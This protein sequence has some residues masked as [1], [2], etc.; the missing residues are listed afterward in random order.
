MTVVRT[1]ARRLGS[2]WLACAALA[3]LLSACSGGNKLPP[4]GTP[5]LTLSSTNTQF[6]SYVVTI[7]AIS[8]A[9]P[10]GVYASLLYQPLTFDL[11]RQTDITELVEAPAVPAD[12]YT[13]ATITIDYSAAVLTINENGTSHQ[14]SPVLLV[15]GQQVAS[16]SFVVTFD[17]NHPLVVTNQ[18]STRL[19]IKFDLDAMNTIDTASQQV[20]IEPF[21]V[22]NPASP[23]LDQTPMR[24]R[25]L[26]VY[27]GTNSFVMNIRPFYNLTAV[28]LGGITVTVDDQTYYNINGVT[29]QGA[30]GLAQL[31]SLPLNTTMAA[32]GVLSSLS[33]ITPTF[34]ATT[35]LMGTSLEDPLQDHLRGVV[36]KRTG[37]DLI[38]SGSQQLVAAAGNA[39]NFP[40]AVTYAPS[41]TVKLSSNTIVSKDGTLGTFGLNDI[42][43]GQQVDVGGTS[44]YDSSG[45]LTFDATSA[46]LRLLNSRAWGVLNSATPNSASL[47]LITFGLWPATAFNF[48][49]TAQ[50]G[51]AVDPAAYP[52][53]TG[54][55]DL[56]GTAAGTL[57]A[58]DGYVVPFGTAPP[59]FNAT[60]ITPG[61]STEQV[62]VVDWSTLSGATKPF[63]TISPTEL[64]VDLSNPALA[65]FHDIYT[66]PEVLNLQ[67]LP[68]SPVITTVGANQSS[69]ELS[70]G[71][72]ALTTGIS[73]FS[74]SS[75]A[76]SAFSTALTTTFNGTNKAG[77]LVAVGHYNSASNTFVA[78]RIDVGLQY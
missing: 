55:S 71:N 24:V 44:T 72:L 23:Q 33:S 13:S 52:V 16:A 48:T 78:T 41:A 5:V 51:G 21:A 49:G 54:T 46:Q 11:T 66:G 75:S 36:S 76:P 34:K 20:H 3:A 70:V 4:P 12:T 18:Q 15:N 9:G 1:E 60:A 25:G 22:L 56:S 58:L 43:V 31:G 7:D 10:N 47:D 27:T 28:P 65:E 37:N 2:P 77:R 68:A 19:N 73:V 17:P 67:T 74:N 62:L 32:Y 26:F 38:L 39:L 30:A 45:N 50:G 14:L 64:I 6:T 59:A 40:G 69:L 35:V 8:L 42:S 57:L 29:Y 63:T 61:A 53:N